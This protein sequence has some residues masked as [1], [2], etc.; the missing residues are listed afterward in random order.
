MFSYLC[1]GNDIE[2]DP[3]KMNKEEEAIKP[4]NAFEKKKWN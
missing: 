4:Y 3:N 2:V 1:K